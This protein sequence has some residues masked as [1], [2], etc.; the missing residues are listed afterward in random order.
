[1]KKSVYNA[2][3]QNPVAFPNLTIRKSKTHG[4]PGK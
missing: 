4:A 2:N 3:R 1:M